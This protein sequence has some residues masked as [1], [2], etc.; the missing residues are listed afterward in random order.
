VPLGRRGVSAHPAVPPADLDSQTVLDPPPLYQNSRSI[1]A[2]HY[3][4]GRDSSPRPG[5]G[6]QPPGP[7][8]STAGACQGCPTCRLGSGVRW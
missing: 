7:G 1:T 5:R 2:T 3:P 8:A 4:R 6:S